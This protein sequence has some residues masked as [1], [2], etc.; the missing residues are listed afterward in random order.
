ME[1]A[2]FDLTLRRALGDRPRGDTLVLLTADHGHAATDPDKLIDLIGD[3]ELLRLLRNPPAG[4]P[5]LVFLH[6][7]HPG[8]VR[9]HLESRWPGMLTI[10]DR[11]ELI[12]AG[13]FGQ[14]DPTVARRRIGELVVL[15]EGDLSASVVKVDGQVF[16]HRGAHGGLTADEMRIPILAWRA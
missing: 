3:E 9:E 13:L 4:E 10:L 14:G 2:L 15:L 1:A 16:R 7:D 6:T 8:R 12:D 5:R 11:D